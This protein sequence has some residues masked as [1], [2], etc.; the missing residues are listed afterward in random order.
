MRIRSHFAYTCACANQYK[1]FIYEQLQSETIDKP[2]VLAMAHVYKMRGDVVRCSITCK[3][4]IAISLGE[5]LF[6]TP[7][8][9]YH[10]PAG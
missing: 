10:V 7:I 4:S 1:I 9:R 8:Y 6:C 3:S 5:T 2:A